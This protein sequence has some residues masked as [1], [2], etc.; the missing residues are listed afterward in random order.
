MTKFEAV[1]LADLAAALTVTKG[2]PTQ[3]SL[4]DGEVPVLS[5]AAVRNAGSPKHYAQAGSN[6]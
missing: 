2:F 4:P 6:C 5:V 3:R 1:R